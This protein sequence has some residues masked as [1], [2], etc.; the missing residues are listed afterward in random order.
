MMMRRLVRWTLDARGRRRAPPHLGLAALF[1][2]GVLGCSGKLD[3]PPVNV[4]AYD[5]AADPGRVTMH[6]LNRVEYNNTIRDLLG[7]TLTP[8]DDFPADDRGYGFDNISDVL[9][10]SPLQLELYERAA[11]ELA[12]EAMHLPSQSET[13]RTEAESLDGQVGAA[14]G[15][16]WNL[17]SAGELPLTYEFPSTGRYKITA[18]LWGQQAGDEPVKVNLL[19]GG[20]VAGNFDVTSTSASPEEVSA[21]AEVTSGTKVVSVEFLNDYYDE[22]S[23]ADRNLMVDWIEV[24]GPL[25]SSG[26]NPIRQKILVCD[27]A[28]GDACVRQIL[29]TFAERAFRRP[30]TT[31]EVDRLAAF[32]KL[33]Q[34]NGESVD[35]GIEL[36]LR[37]I[38]TSPHFVFRVEVDPAP[39]S[40]EKHPLNDFELASRLSYFLWSSMP[41]DELFEAARAGL[42][43]DPVELEAQVRRMLEDPKAEALTDNFAGQWLHTRALDDHVPDYQAFP[44]WNDELKESMRTETGLFFREFLYGELPVS[45]MLTADFTFLNDTLAAHYGLESPGEEFAKVTITDPNRSGLLTQGSLLTVTSFPTR[46]SPVKRG[47]W[48]LTQLL[49]DEPP[50]PPA[51]VEGLMNEEIPTGSIRDRLE[52]HRTKPECAACHSL[53]DPLG[54]GLESFDGIGAFRTMDQNFPVDATGEMPTGEKFNGARE[55]SQIVS[56]DERFPECVAEKMFTYALG[57]GPEKTDAPYLDHVNQEFTA[58]GQRLKEL[59]V[60]IATSEPFRMRRG[61]SPEGGQQ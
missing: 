30:P 60:I 33:A 2:L 40:L 23:G 26:A 3:D 21:E 27:P 35:K 42:L 56:S 6:R 47:K 8:A 12:L 51:G 44:D 22:V 48:V 39:S 61:E 55:L 9:S 54:F 38:L 58:R 24:E 14:S 52:K 25:D 17:W 19:V 32:V 31:E 36:A 20:A 4:T 53:M 15:E 49:C 10:I 5:P 46:T 1:A 43:Q 57:R 16:A 11:E 34:D 45:Q 13:N 28:T 37:A 18:R 7:T 59:I 41:D 29:E 50:P